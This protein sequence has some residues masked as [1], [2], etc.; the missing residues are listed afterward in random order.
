MFTIFAHAVLVRYVDVRVSIESRHRPAPVTAFRRLTMALLDD[1]N[2]PQ[3]CKLALGVCVDDCRLLFRRRPS[4][5][6]SPFQ[7]LALDDDRTSY[8]CRPH[9]A[10]FRPCR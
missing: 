3:R 7:W 5:L 6:H 4:R 1:R 2:S 8:L 9:L 10:V